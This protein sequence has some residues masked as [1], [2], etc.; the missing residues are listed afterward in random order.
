MLFRRPGALGLAALLAFAGCKSSN[1]DAGTR[2]GDPLVKG[3]NIPRQNMPIPDRLG[4]NGAD[5]LVTP[6]SKPPDKQ[7]GY[8]DDPSRFKGTYIE[9]PNTALAA[10]AGKMRDSDELKIDGNENRVPLLQAGATAPAKPFEQSA[11]VESLYRELERYGCK[12]GDRTLTQENGKYVFR[13]TVT[14]P[15][16]NGARLQCTET[17]ATA[18]EAIK[19]VLDD[20]ATEP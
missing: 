5:P 11:A 8:S 6:T 18:E 10:L 9:G 16:S 19:K 15:A 3:P 4:A 1:S 12:S 14:R 13:A 20:V 7:V 2:G 17:G